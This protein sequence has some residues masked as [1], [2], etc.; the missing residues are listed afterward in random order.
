MSNPSY[1][2]QWEYTWCYASKEDVLNGI[3]GKADELGQNGWE[4]INF[5][6]SETGGF[7]SGAA[8]FKR[9]VA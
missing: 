1:R 9:P 3:M 7:V 6:Y 8:F 5:Y 2:Q 4:M